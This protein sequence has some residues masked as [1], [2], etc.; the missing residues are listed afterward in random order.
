MNLPKCE[1]TYANN[2]YG[3]KRGDVEIP[4]IYGDSE[5]VQYIIDVINFVG[6]VSDVH[7]QD[8]VDDYMN[9]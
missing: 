8:I 1:I 4:E 9:L 5:F 6:D 7:L 3:L 2:T